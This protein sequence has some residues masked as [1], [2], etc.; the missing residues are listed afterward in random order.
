MWKEEKR[1]VKTCV[2][3]ASTAVNLGVCSIVSISKAGTGPVI[4]SLSAPILH[5]RTHTH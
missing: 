5:N 2:D 4:V 1:S 3:E